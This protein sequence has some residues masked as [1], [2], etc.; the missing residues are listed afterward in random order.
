M[1]GSYFGPR[2]K[3]DALKM[4]KAVMS[5][6][7]NAITIVTLVSETGALGKKIEKITTTPNIPKTTNSPARISFIRVLVVY[8]SS[9]FGRF[10]LAGA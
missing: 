3:P 4:A 5:N 2:R 8:E 6:P 7:K 9:L 10:K 1:A